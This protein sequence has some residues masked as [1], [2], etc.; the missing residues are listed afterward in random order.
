M[1]IVILTGSPRK[2]GN[3]NSLAEQFAKGAG[4]AGHEVFKFDCAKQKVGGC[5]ACDFCGMDGPCS[6][7]DDFSNIL[8]PQLEAADMIVLVS[9]IY[10][11]GLSS[12]LKTVID[13]FY[14]LNEAVQNKKSALIV[15]MAD[16]TYSSAFSAVD[17]YHALGEYLRWQN[18]GEL[19]GLGLWGKDDVSGSPYVSQAYELGRSL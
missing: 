2:K 19:V 14:A 9:P 10:Y 6:Q 7:K 1:K 18:V 5:L 11:Y 17:H 12:Q 16:E 13:R 4:E 8:R 15:T 3:S